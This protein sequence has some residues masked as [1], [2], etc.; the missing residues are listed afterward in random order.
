[1]SITNDWIFRKEFIEENN[2]I[3]NAK[4][5]RCK[6]VWFVEDLANAAG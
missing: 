4:V 2:Q 5:Y 6:S 1:M 3:K